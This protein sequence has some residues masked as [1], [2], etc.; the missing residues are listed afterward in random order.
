VV[1]MHARG[2][3]QTMQKNPVYDDVLLDVYD[4][5]ERRIEACEQAGIE[6]AR[7]IIDPGI[8]FGKTVAHNLA[9]IE[10]L[11]LFHGLGCPVLLGVSRKSFIGALTGEGNPKARVAGSLAAALSGADRGVAVLRV[12]DVAETVQAL[13]I[14]RATRF[15]GEEGSQPPAGS[16]KLRSVNH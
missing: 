12:H 9:L 6:R 8:G 2:E 15:A 7:I 1:L 10:G 5:L 14:W 3:P 13:T 16:I 4:Y 11:A